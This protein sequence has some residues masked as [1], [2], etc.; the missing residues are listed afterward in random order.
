MAKH[1]MTGY[2]MTG[3]S[4]SLPPVSESD[5]EGPEPEDRYTHISSPDLARRRPLIKPD[6]GPV[7]MKPADIR[8]GCS[9]IAPMAGQCENDQFPFGRWSDG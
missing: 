7:Q 4:L 9:F 6:D 8:E 1:R 5:P 2:V 3:P